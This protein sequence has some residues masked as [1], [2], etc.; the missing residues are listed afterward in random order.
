MEVNEE[1]IEE[2][3]A[4]TTEEQAG[5]QEQETGQDQP[6]KYT[7]AEVDKIIARKIAA[8]RKR[9]AKLAEE[10]QQE[11]QQESDFQRREKELMKRELRADARDELTEK[12]LPLCIMDV[13]NYESKEEYEQSMKA[14]QNLV[15]ELHKAWEIKRCTGRTPKAY[16]SGNSTDGV[17]RNAF[18]P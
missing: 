5:A 13:L 12:E 16:T 6:K 11:Q 1:M 15:A 2:V 7:D 10:Q 4:A 17:I 9:A 8:E 3:D 14:A 18:R